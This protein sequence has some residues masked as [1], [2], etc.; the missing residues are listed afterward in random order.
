[1]E[2]IKNYLETMFQGLPQTNEIEHLKEELLV[3]ME[4]KYQELKNEGKSENEAIGKVISEFG[5]IDELLKEM[6]IWETDN[7]PHFDNRPFL[8]E[9]EAEEYVKKIRENGKF[10]GLGVSLILIGVSL[11]IFLYQITDNGS[12]FKS[13]NANASDYIPMLALFI[14][15]VPAIGLFVYSGVRMERFQYIE[16]GCFQLDPR[17]RTKLQEMY[18]DNSSTRNINIVFGVILCVLSPVSIFVGGI[19][20]DS[21]AVYGVCFLLLMI[22]AAVNLFITTGTS[23]EGYK[24]ILKIMEFSDTNKKQDRIIGTIASIV[25]PL[26]AV[27]YL[28]SGIC[29]DRWG[30]NW[31]IFPVVG[32]LFGIFSSVYKSIVGER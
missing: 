1:M 30:E 7:N 6:G 10:V 31:I 5:N 21:G 13:F 25:W 4:D 14:F 15:I 17:L 28:I 20:S 26:A 18:R 24:K 27:F 23:S 19:F 8:L 29:F 32:I 9:D 2:T 11:M 22:A 16:D 3:N 12:L